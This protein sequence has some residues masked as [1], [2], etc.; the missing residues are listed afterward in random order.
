[1]IDRQLRRQADT[2]MT[3]PGVDGVLALIKGHRLSRLITKRCHRHGTQVP[4]FDGVV[5]TAKVQTGVEQVAQGRAVEQRHGDSRAN[6]HQMVADE[7]AGL[8]DHPRPIATQHLMTAKALPEFGQLVNGGAEV[9]S[10][11]G[12]LHGIDGAGR[13]AD[14]HRE[15]IWS[16]GRQQ[17]SYPGQYADLISRPCTATGKNQPGDR[18]CGGDLS[19]THDRPSMTRERIFIIQPV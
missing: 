18:L 13:G 3:Q 8:M 19:G 5:D 9:R 4:G 7:A 12:Q 6:A 15:R 1:M 10:T 16:T 11:A 2:P 14:D 17:I